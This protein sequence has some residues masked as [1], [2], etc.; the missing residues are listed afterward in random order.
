MVERKPYDAIYEQIDPRTGA[1]LGWPRGSYAK[2]TD[3]LARLR[4]AEPHATA[5]RLIELEREAAQATSL[6]PTPT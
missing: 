5:G 4:A 1:K 2:F 6:R 3:Q